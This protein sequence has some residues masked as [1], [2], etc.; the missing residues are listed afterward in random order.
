MTRGPLLIV[1]HCR[2]STLCNTATNSRLISR[3]DEIRAAPFDVIEFEFEFE[4]D[5]LSASLKIRP[6]ACL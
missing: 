2:Y 6:P 5:L 3:I 1:Y 4:F